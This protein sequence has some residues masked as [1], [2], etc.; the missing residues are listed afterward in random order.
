MGV[1]TAI[2]T[3]VACTV[4]ALGGG[5]GIGYAISNHQ[6]KRGKKKEKNIDK[7]LKI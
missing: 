4:V 5:I 2:V 1:T 3:G 6:K 7:D